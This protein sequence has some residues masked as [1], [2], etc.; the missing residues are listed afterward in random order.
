M[1][2][3]VL[4]LLNNGLAIFQIQTKAPG[5]VLFEQVCHQL[6]LLEANHFG[7]DYLDGYG[8]L[9]W[10]DLSKTMKD[11]MA[12][13]SIKNTLLWFCLKFYP[14]DSAHLK[15]EYTKFLFFLQISKCGMV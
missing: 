10:L 4:K 9:Y 14:S 8:T 12:L 6:R 5:C 13:S 1:M 2:A 3:V 7:L 15:E 11:Q